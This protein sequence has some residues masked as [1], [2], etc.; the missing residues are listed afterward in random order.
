MGECLRVL[1]LAL[2]GASLFGCIPDEI[3]ERDFAR[4]GAK[5]MCDRERECDRGSWL[6]RYYGQADCRAEWERDLQA[7]VDLYD[8]LDCDYDKKE[9]AR[10]YEDLVTMDCESWYEDVYADQGQVLD[11][12]WDEC[13]YFNPFPTYYGATR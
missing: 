13:Q 6:N 5:A 1:G 3:E 9:A 7:L 10:A 4:L 2:I 11:E 12:V 8:D